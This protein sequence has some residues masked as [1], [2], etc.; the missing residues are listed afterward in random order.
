MSGAGETGFAG[1]LETCLYHSAAEG[2]AIEE[3][4][5]GA[6]GLRVVSRWKGALA[7]RIGTGVLL[8]FERE[9][10]AERDGPI[11][12]HGAGGRG[13][14]CL[15]AP[16]ASYEE[17]RERLAASAIEITH[18][19]D[20]EGGRRSF[21]LHDPAGNLIEIADGDLWPA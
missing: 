1:V 18:D 20:W 11:A 17:W 9:A 14:A 10:L 6:L 3:F 13:H 5:V 8:L 7:L 19:H 16:G 12:A 21:Y 15:L 4:Y 2:E